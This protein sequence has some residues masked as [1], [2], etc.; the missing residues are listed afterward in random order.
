[1]P[2]LIRGIMIAMGVV[3]L[4]LCTVCDAPAQNGTVEE[5]AAVA[6]EEALVDAV[7]GFEDEDLVDLEI[8][9]EEKGAEEEV[10]RAREDAEEIL[11]ML[12]VPARPAEPAPVASEEEFARE[13]GRE[14]VVVEIVEDS[15][16]ETPV[17]E[18]VSADVI[19]VIADAAPP[20]RDKDAQNL[21][22]E[23]P[24]VAGPELESMQGAAVD[25]TSLAATELESPAPEIADMPAREE[26]AGG[27]LADAGDAE[28]PAEIIELEA[29]FE[30]T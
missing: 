11:D 14:P 21:G 10:R 2:N 29:S 28:I 13:Q 5:E 3:G 25:A 23:E 16:D 15:A 20:A 17:A 1:M 26:R 9:S 22:L 30:R 18:D 27:Q 24:G 4:V 6:A 8:G 12:A 19:A 7:T